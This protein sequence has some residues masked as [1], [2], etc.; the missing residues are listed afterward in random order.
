MKEHSQAELIGQARK[1]LL[2]IVSILKDGKIDSA[3][4]AAVFGLMAYIKHGGSLIMQERKEY[5]DLITKAVHLISLDPAVK[6][7]LDKPLEY[8]PKKEA[9]A[10]RVLRS[11]PG[12]MAERDRARSEQ[13]R[14]ALAQARTDRLE[15]GRQL[16]QQKYFDGALQHFTRM[17]DDYPGDAELFAR[18]GKMLFDINHIECITFLEK[19]V[20]ADPSDH[21]SLALTGV[22]FRKIKKFEQAERAYLA[23]LEASPDNVNYLF[24]LS[25][26]YIDA[27]NWTKA[28]QT[29]RRV[30]ELDPGLEPA[31]KGLEFATRH[32]RDCL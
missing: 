1:H 21:K 24:N 10:L 11:L 31:Q 9:E 29:L 28:Q 30:L 2:N 3:I 25:R 14:E 18:I 8:T 32:C 4:K 5:Q 26:V 12:L 7:V 16:L 13:R 22:A 17:C 20:Q 23:A 6:E 27:A 19:A 15:K